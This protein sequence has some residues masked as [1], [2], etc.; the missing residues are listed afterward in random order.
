MAKRQRVRGRLLYLLS[1]WI[2]MGIGVSACRTAPHEMIANDTDKTKMELTLQDTGQTYPVNTIIET[3]TGNPVDYDTMLKDLVGVRIVF[4]GEIHNQPSHHEIQARLI[5]S[6]H[7]RHSGLTVGME[8]FD[9]RYDPVLALWSRGE[10]ERDD[11]IARS[12]WYVRDSGWGFPF[13]LYAP[14]FDCVRDNHLRLVGLNVPFWIPPKISASGLAYLLPDERLLVA[15]SVDLSNAAHRAYVEDVF[16]NSHA[17]HGMS[18]E[19]FYEA[20]CAWED[21]MASSIARK[22]GEDPMVVI[23]G[24][25]HIVRRFGVPDRT[26]ARNGQPSRTVYLAPVGTT[27]ALDYAD[28]IWVTPWEDPHER[29]ADLKVRTGVK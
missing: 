7:Q 24:N 13:D 6:L 12:H 26:F 23:I 3:R 20:Q 22:L 8:M 10:V 2:V 18:F 1:A 15:E 11:F 21:T 16:N 17:H 14:V 25:G 27:V 19:H 5:E 9:H 4:I 29:S 28:Y